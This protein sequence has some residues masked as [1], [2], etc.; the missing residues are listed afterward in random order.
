VSRYILFFLPFAVIAVF[1][2]MAARDR[3]RNRDSGSLGFVQRNGVALSTYLLLAVGFWTIMIIVLPQLYMIEYSF[4]PNLTAAQ[5]GGPKD[6]YTLANYR[7]LIFGRPGDS[8]ALNWLHLGAFLHTIVISVLITV[9]DF[10]FCYPLAYYMAQVA[11]GG[12]TRLLILCLIVPFWV[13]E[14]LR[15][16]AF[17]ILFGTS[18]LVDSVLVATGLL[19]EPYDFLKHDIGLYAGLSYAYILSMIFPLYNAIESLDKNQ[20]EAARDL[21]AP[22]WHIHLFIVMPYAKPGI[23]S[24]CTL[25]FMLCAGAL[26]APQILGGPSSLWFT[27]VVYNWFFQ[28][29]DW[30]RG[31]AYAFALL[32]SCIIFVLAMLRLFKVSLAEIAR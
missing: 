27:Q 6:V 4:R 3:R 20:I 21:G 25:V 9:F 12:R 23:A 22:W 5:T 29:F 2:L 8:E 26:A 10:C 30:T 31:S 16:F 7:Y 13:N 28:A 18:G 14:L 1:A 32:I 11:R 24:G 19:S 17:K 15:A